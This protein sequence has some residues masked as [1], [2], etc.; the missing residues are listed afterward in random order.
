MNPALRVDNFLGLLLVPEVSKE[1]VPAPR[2]DFSHS[3]LVRVEDRR[4]KVW[5]RSAHASLSHARALEASS[6]RSSCLTTAKQ[7][8]HWHI[9]RHEVVERLCGEWC[10]T[11]VESSGHRVCGSVETESFVDS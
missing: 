5:I 4:L 2:T 6:L 3:V 8:H 9:Q 11:R 10:R 7:L 1:H